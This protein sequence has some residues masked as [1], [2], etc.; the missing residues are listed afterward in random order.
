MFLYSWWVGWSVCQYPIIWCSWHRSGPSTRW[1]VL[2]STS[3]CW[4]GWGWGRGS[5]IWSIPLQ[6]CS[7]KSLSSA[8]YE[9][10]LHWSVFHL[11]KVSSKRSSCLTL[12]L[13]QFLQTLS[14]GLPVWFKG[15]S[16]TKECFHLCSP[17]K[18]NQKSYVSVTDFLK[19]WEVAAVCACNCAKAVGQR[20]H[21]VVFWVAPFLGWQDR[22]VILYFLL[23]IYS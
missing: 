18:S 8:C 15:T 21:Q 7:H 17:S 4:W 20:H 19:M 3:G 1:D 10:S 12:F 6:I 22:G 9:C 5:H 23:V 16:W 14:A 2:G 11:I 13:S